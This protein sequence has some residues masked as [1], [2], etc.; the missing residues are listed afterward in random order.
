MRAFFRITFE[1]IDT[2]AATELLATLQEVLKELPT[3][4]VELNLIGSK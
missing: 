2:Q 4:Q 3:S 1:E